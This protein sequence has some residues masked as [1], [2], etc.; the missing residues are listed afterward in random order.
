M[1]RAADE[2]KKGVCDN[3]SDDE[4]MGSSSSRVTGERRVMGI[5]RQ[6]DRRTDE[7]D[8]TRMDPLLSCASQVAGRGRRVASV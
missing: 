8:G 3:D 5:E 6:T 2:M 1:G 4:Q 7:E